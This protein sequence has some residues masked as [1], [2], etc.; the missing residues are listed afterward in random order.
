MMTSKIIYCSQL[1]LV[2]I[3][4]IHIEACDILQTMTCHCYSS[5]NN[6]SEQLKCSNYY[7][8]TNGSIKLTNGTLN[9]RRSFDTFHLTF[10]AR[11]FN[12]SAMFINELSYLFA[13]H[14]RERTIKITLT[15]QDYLQLN[16]EDYAFYQLFGEQSEQKTIFILEL[17]SNGKLTFAPMSFFQLHADQVSIHVSSLEPYSF[18][19]LFNHTKIDLL[20]IEGRSNQFI[21]LC[22]IQIET[23]IFRMYTKN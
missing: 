9:S 20:N 17:T 7:V 18:E 8:P 12:V 5:S 19:E 14:D 4:R 15:F 1:F 23:F 3:I 2:L 22:L 11:E 16:F 21:I 10:H 6:Q 13:R